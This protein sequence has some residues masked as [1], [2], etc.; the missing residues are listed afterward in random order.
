MGYAILGGLILGAICLG[1]GYL[2][3]KKG[4]VIDKARDVVKSA[5][6][7]AAEKLSK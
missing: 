6:D 7:S 2:L 1:V 4:K 3:G 5:I